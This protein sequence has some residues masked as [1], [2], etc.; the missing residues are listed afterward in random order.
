MELKLV[1]PFLELK[2]KYIDYIEEWESSG[3]K[4]VP[5][6]TKSRSM[7]YHELLSTWEADK[8]DHMYEKGFV[9][10]PLYF[11]V[12]KNDKI[13]G[14]LHFRHELND[15]LLAYGGHIGYGVRPSVFSIFK[16]QFFN[17]K[18]HSIF[19]IFRDKNR[20]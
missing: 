12:D 4:I 11:L 18:F 15:N 5:Y 16:A 20:T 7:S 19:N 1:E 10:A 17:I 2:D 3:E 6:A 13:L 14:A 8:T 9:P